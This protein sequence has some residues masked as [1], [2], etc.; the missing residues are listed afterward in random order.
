M[1]KLVLAGLV[2]A[3][4]LV[5]NVWAQKVKW[6]LPNEK[7]CTQNGGT[8]VGGQYKFRYDTCEA[9]WEDANKICKSI[10]GELPNNDDLKNVIRDCGGVVVYVENESD[11]SINMINKNYQECVRKKGFFPGIA[12]GYWSNLTDQE[13]GY[14]FETIFFDGRMVTTPNKSPSYV[15]CV[16]K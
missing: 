6:I 7:N 10:G 13:T 12:N 8:S 5:G 11:T 16:K 2:A 4:V 3:S 14:S 1:K 15:H 9:T